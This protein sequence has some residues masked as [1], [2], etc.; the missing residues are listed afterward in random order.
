MDRNRW[1]GRKLACCALLPA[2][3]NQ[4]A[5][6]AL[7]AQHMCTAPQRAALRPAV[8]S[9]EHMET[10]RQRRKVRMM[11]AVQQGAVA[12]LRGWLAWPSAWRWSSTV[13]RR[14]AR[15]VVHSRMTMRAGRAL[16]VVTTV[17]MTQ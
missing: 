14:A 16:A 7:P 15:L 1:L 12:G 6:A 13:C 11:M 10:Q 3:Q 5:R 8:A 9:K 17:P 4:H 2:Q